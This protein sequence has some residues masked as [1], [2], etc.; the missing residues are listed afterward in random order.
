MSDLNDSILINAPNIIHSAL[1]DKT[2][3]IFILKFYL[4]AVHKLNLFNF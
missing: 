4:G 2:N 3:V 1:D